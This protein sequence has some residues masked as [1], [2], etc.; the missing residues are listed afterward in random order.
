[1]VICSRGPEAGVVSWTKLSP[2]SSESLAGSSIW[3]RE[4]PITAA[5]N[6][7]SRPWLALEVRWPLSTT[8]GFMKVGNR[9]VS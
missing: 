2:V 8:P 4:L 7:G 3:P 5:L 6:R 1:M 9:P